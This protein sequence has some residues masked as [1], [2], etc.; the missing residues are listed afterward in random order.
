MRCPALPR[1]AGHGC[2]RCHCMVDNARHCRHRPPCPAPIVGAPLVGARIAIHCPATVA[3][4]AMHGR[5]GA[6]GGNA[7]HGGR[8]G[9]CGPCGRCGQCGHRPHRPAPIAGAPL[10]GAR[11]ATLP[12]N[13]GNDGS[14]WSLW[15]N[16]R[17]CGAMRAM[18]PLA[19]I[20][21][22]AG[23]HKRCPYDRCM[24]GPALIHTLSWQCR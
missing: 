6:M 7:R 4:I 3:T 13:G 21:C 1:M 9:P 14:A 16:G 5:C 2:T 19:C 18:F 24:H 10:V 23:T 22:I 12:G 11:I 17:Q 8:C 15:S 20:G